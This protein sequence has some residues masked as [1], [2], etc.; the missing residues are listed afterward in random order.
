V[1]VVGCGRLVRRVLTDFV[2]LAVDDC[3][4]L[5]VLTVQPL[6]ELMGRLPALIVGMVA[7]AEQELAA[8]GGIAPD[9]PAARLV[10]VVLLD[11]LVDARA[12]RAEDAELLQVRAEP[13]PE[14]VVRAGLVD[15]ARVHLEPVTEQRRVQNPEGDRRRSGAYQADHADQA[16]PHRRSPP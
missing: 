4:A 6:D 12:D 3:L 1:Y 13:G 5:Q 16:P 9:P 15:G 8:R 7:V 14:P 2:E 10:A 11:Q